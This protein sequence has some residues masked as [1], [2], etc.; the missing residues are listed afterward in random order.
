M[1]SEMYFLI[2][3]GI[4]RIWPRPTRKRHPVHTSPIPSDLQPPVARATVR[5]VGL[6]DGLQRALLH[7]ASTLSW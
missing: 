3:L 1:A 5:E 7:K 6:R 4:F 2:H